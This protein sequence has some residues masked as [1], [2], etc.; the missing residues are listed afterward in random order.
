[1]MT[2]QQEG[3]G[4]FHLSFLLFPVYRFKFLLRGVWTLM[5]T[6]DNNIIQIRH[7]NIKREIVK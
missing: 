4:R 7:S 5:L 3:C 6:Q 2:R 1:M